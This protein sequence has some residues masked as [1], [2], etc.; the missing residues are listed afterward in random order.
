MSSTT[1]AVPLRERTRLEIKQH[2]LELFAERG[3]EATSLADI[4][5]AVGC[6]K[7]TVLYHFENKA[8]ILAEVLAPAADHLGVVLTEL[9]T[10]PADT[11]QDRA[12]DAFIDVVVRFRGLAVMFGGSDLLFETPAFSSVADLCRLLPQLLAGGDDDERMSATF[13]AL[14]GAV[15]ECRDPSRDD[16]SLR[17]VLQMCMRRLLT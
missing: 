9:L 15:A 2:A 5:V 11:V 6:S 8:A 1:T 7:A 10:Y 17:A 16:D 12:I 4:A 13:F 14:N 3:Y